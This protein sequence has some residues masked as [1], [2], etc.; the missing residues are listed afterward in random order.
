MN[1]RK[2]KWVLPASLSVLLCVASHKADA[3]NQDS[4]KKLYDAGQVA[5]AKDDV[6]TAYEE[7]LQAFKKDPKDLRSSP[8]LRE[9]NSLCVDGA[10]KAFDRAGQRAFIFTDVTDMRLCGT[11]SVPH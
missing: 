7:Y 8:L 9:G 11:K 1:S 10:A 5:E 3:R 6:V 4:A 2:V